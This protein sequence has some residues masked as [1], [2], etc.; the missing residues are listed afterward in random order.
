MDIGILGT[1]AVGTALAT[2]FSEAGHD[3]V[4]GS[5]SP[6][7]TGAEWP[8]RPHAEAIAHGAVVVLAV[9]TAA[10]PAVARDHREAL[11]GTVVIDP[12]NEYPTA[13]TEPSA[14]SRLA[15]AAPEAAVVKAFNTIGANRM[16]EPEL[17]DTKITMFIAG[18]DPEATATVAALAA[19]VGFD[20][21]VTGDLEQAAHLE[22]VAR[23]WID[24]SQELGRD[25]GFRLLGAD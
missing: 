14:A 18:D 21:L 5:R 24:L 20:P 23:L 10:A 7:T 9:P 8:V 11:A 13:E 2:A 25:I 3:V 1:G 17:E 19:D 4:L 15:E 6:E 16:T 12:T 22:A